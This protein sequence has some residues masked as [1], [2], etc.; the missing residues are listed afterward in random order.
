MAKTKPRV[1]KNYEK[2]DEKLREEIAARYPLGYAQDI[3]TFDIGG[4]RFM[5]GLPF[6]TDE[7]SYIIKFPA[8]AENISDLQDEDGGAEDDLNL[9]GGVDVDE[10]EEPDEVEKPMDLDDIDVADES[11]TDK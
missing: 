1:I 7:Y 5:T 8:A 6:E 11:T 4:G 10:E 3:K 9:E 2:L